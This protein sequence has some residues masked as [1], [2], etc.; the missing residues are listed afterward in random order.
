MSPDDH[1]VNSHIYNT[2]YLIQLISL[3]V[4]V[5]ISDMFIFMTV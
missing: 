1:L 5:N 4:N 3:Y 2:R